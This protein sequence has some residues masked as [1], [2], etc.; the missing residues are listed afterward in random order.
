MTA[1][2]WRKMRRNWRLPAS[3]GLFAQSFVAGPLFSALHCLQSRTTAQQRSKANLSNSLVV[4]GYWRSG[5][6]LLH[7][8][9]SL[10]SRF[11]YP[12]TY[13]CMNPQH[14]MLTQ[15][16]ALRGSSRV[17]RRPMDAVEISASSPQEE[18]FALLSLGARSPYEALLAPSRLGDALRLG[19]PEDLPEMECRD[20]QDTFEYFLRGVSVVE[21]YRPLI[22]KSPP[23][24]YRVRLLRRLLPDARFALI[25]R[26]PAIVYES[27]VRMWRKLFEM[28]SLEEIPPEEETRRAV[29]EDRPRFES[30]LTAGLSDLPSDRVALIRYEHLVSDPLGAVEGLYDKLKLGS[31]SAVRTAMAASIAR[32][33]PYEARNAMPPADWRSRLREEWRSIF[34]E[35]G[36]QAD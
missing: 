12:S 16:A 7:Q 4:L 6:T 27:T 33:G 14:F 35:Y 26:S 22:L 19:D 20:W 9:L 8:Y 18:E 15:A 28:Y 29:L 23:H 34:E 30:K 32:R 31:F 36:Y 17:V 3:S 2:A 24:G 25:V 1:G 11:G 21:G 10:D 5:T 13:S